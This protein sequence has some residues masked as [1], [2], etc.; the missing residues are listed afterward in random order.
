MH[1]RYGF[2]TNNFSMENSDTHFS[3]G[4]DELSKPLSTSSKIGG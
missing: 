4:N 3:E 2:K 1:E